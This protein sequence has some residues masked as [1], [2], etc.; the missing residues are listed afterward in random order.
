M[1]VVCQSN[2][3]TALYRKAALAIPGYVCHS[4]VA[5]SGFDRLVSGYRFH[6]G[7]PPHGGTL[8]VESR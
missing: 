6:M 1:S 7:I 3:M 2:V 4:P 8:A 5:P